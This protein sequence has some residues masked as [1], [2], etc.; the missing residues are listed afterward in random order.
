MSERQ[1]CPYHVILC[2]VNGGDVVWFCT[3]SF[4]DR[5]ISLSLCHLFVLHYQRNAER[6]QQL[7]PAFREKNSIHGS[8]EKSS[9]PE[10]A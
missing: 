7:F 5:P 8:Q 1:L 4:T 3:F 9:I 6:L 10:T 2:H